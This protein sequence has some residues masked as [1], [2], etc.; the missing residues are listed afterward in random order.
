MIDTSTITAQGKGLGLIPINLPTTFQILAGSVSTGQVHSTI[1]GPRGE[2]VHVKLY[3][4]LNGD[5]I[6]EFTP[7][8]AGKHRIDILYANQP[9]AGSPFIATAYDIRAAEITN[10]PKELVND[11]ENF[12]EVN[13]SR[14]SNIE[15]DVKITSPSGA[16]LPVSYE[17][18]NYKK[19]RIVPNELG[20]HR[21][22]LLLGGE[23]MS[24][25]PFNINC[26]DSR[27]PIARGNGLHH[28]LEDRPASFQVDSQGLSGSLDVKIEGPQ[29]YTKNQIDLQED[30][31]YTVKYTPV[32]VGQFKIFIKWNDR[33]IPGSPFISYVVN[34]EKVK[35][36]G[37]W[38]SILDNYNSLNL[39]LY[40]EKVINF[41]T[42][43][44]GPG[45]SIL[46]KSYTIFLT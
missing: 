14:M 12:M 22:E 1:T 8:A 10:L 43:E 4:Q 26:I 2:N 30:G 40:E 20:V 37:G 13:L 28:G 7:L 9:V 35:V 24:G 25:S 36:V 15:F 29:Q 21:V 31:S 19:I 27:L 32:E 3:Q 34:P 42:S 41:D 23:H 5:Y 45:T 46:F 18:T 16:Q 39:K 17:G 6:G 38:Q 44:A 11:N 33:E